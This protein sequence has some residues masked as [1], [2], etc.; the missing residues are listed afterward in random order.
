MLDGP[1]CI[2]PRILSLCRFIESPGKNCLWPVIKRL[3]SSARWHSSA[4]QI[5]VAHIGSHRQLPFGLSPSG[6]LLKPIF[7]LQWTCWWWTD[8]VGISVLRLKT[9][10][11]TDTIARRIRVKRVGSDGGARGIRRSRGSRSRVQERQGRNKS[12]RPVVF[13]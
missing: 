3:D 8:L 12:A 9:D 5:P 6:R 7:P 1:P 2:I 13:P 11:P 10:A 4:R